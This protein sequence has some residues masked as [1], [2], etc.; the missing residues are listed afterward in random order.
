MKLVDRHMR[1]RLAD[2]LDSAR[3]VVLHGARQCGKT[4]LARA[5]AT[6][7]NGTYITL[8][9]KQMLDAALADPH[10]FLRAY[11]PPLIIDEVQLGGERLIREVKI[12]V[13]ENS[14]RTRFLLTGSTNFL[15]VPTISESLAGRAL[16]LRLWP[17]SQAELAG[18]APDAAHG[19]R[20]DPTPVPVASCL[21]PH[22]E[23]TASGT[24]SFVG[25]W[26][27]GGGAAPGTSGAR[28]GDLPDRGD[29][30]E[31]V[32]TGGYPEV[33]HLSPNGRAE[34][35]DSYV[36][37]VISRD[38]VQIGD[39]RRAGLLGRLLR[40]AAAD[41]AREVNI[42]RWSQ[43][44]GADR[45]TVESYLGWLRTVFLVHELPSWTR[46]RSARVVRR[47]KLH[48]TDSGLAAAMTGIGA[49][50]LRSPTATATGPLLETFVVS[51][52]ARQLAASS[53]RVTLYHY[54]DNARREAD[55]IL[56]RPDG[57]V[58]A[59]EIK[60]TSSPRASDLRHIATLRD[61][62][63]RSEPGAFRMGVMMHT[64]RHALSLGDR[65]LS[66]PIAALWQ[67]S[68]RSGV[69]SSTTMPSASQDAAR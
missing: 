47:P 54:R 17:F 69:A 52:V 37:T 20:A 12:A 7:R 1:H 8:D 59:L 23:Q 40:L 56:E 15:T 49:A 5:V 21:P 45:A 64:G 66:V 39:V 48:L 2:S 26:F 46:N 34:W 14:A 9:D 32:C 55:L 67:T 50:A 19:R 25:R 62:L 33:Q 18:A 43:Q 51:E 36:E 3:V 4:T 30:M 42:A 53:E 11:E 60:A 22:G 61:G 57:A 38:I 35:F 28:L 63:D 27:D 31:M 6:E 13:D 41:T 68:H 24:A 16:I 58:I 29:Y 10:N 44:L 65:L